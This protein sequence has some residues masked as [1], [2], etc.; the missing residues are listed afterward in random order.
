MT[1]Q[2]D[3]NEFK[4]R[5]IAFGMS[6]KAKADGYGVEWRGKSLEVWMNEITFAEVFAAGKEEKCAKR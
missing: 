5:W 6:L 1:K 3:D 4:R 2:E